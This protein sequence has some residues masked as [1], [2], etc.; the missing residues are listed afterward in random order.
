M[1]RLAKERRFKNDLTRIGTCFTIKSLLLS[2][3]L[4]L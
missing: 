1:S 3:L 2:S 4:S